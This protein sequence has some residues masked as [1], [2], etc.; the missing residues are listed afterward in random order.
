VRELASRQTP[1]LEDQ[2]LFKVFSPRQ[3]AFT[4]AKDSCPA[5]L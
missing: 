2:D 5:P 1:S 4:M 3:V